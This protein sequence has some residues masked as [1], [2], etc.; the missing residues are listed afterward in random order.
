MFWLEAGSV[1]N[2]NSRSTLNP[3][4]AVNA[5]RRAAGFAEPASFER[6]TIRPKMRRSLSTSDGPAYRGGRL[7]REEQIQFPVSRS[8]RSRGGT[9]FHS[10]GWYL[11][12]WDSYERLD[13]ESTVMICRLASS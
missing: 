5:S 1:E 6:A 9:K 10:Y 3:P 7:A 4:H 12:Y 13:M 2:G 8:V 11:E